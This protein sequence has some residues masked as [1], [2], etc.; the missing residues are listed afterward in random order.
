MTAVDFTP[1]SN[2]HRVARRALEL[3]D[4]I[5]EED[6]YAVYGQLVDLC[7]TR[8]AQAAQ[9]LMTF[10]AWFDMDT[11]PSVLAARAEAITAR[12]TA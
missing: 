5:R 7:A 6:N 3:A 12:R 2:I 10:A 4:Q 9:V 1:D 8:P 11:R